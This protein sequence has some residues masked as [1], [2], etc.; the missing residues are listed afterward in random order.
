MTKL[1]TPISDQDH[2]QGNP[3][4]APITLVEYGDYECPFS[5][6]AYPVVRKI[7]KALGRDLVFVFRNFPLAQMHP[8]AL[9]AALA[10]ETAG[11]QG[12]FWPMHDMLYENQDRLE[13]DDLLNYAAALGLEVD[14]FL[15]DFS[16]EQVQLRVRRDFMGGVRSGVRSTPTFFINGKRYV[17]SYA[18]GDL[19][20]ALRS[21]RLGLGQRGATAYS[22]A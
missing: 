14:R 18:Y 8:H 16:S 21:V 1:V 15:I 17:G 13:D 2:L 7:Q 6:E 11:L 10:A 19:L 5:R 20:A 12:K 9:H 4:E 22:R 3:Q